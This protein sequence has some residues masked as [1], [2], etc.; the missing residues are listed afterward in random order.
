MSSAEVRRLVIGVGN[1]DRGDDGA[2]PAVVAHLRKRN[3][4][5]IALKTVSGEA[6]ELIRAWQDADSVVIVDAARCG[7]AAGTVR[8][9]DIGAPDLAIA[10][11]RASTHGLGVAEA[12]ALAR[13]IGVLPDDGVV[14]TIAGENFRPGESLSGPVAAAVAA[15]AA[16][17]ADAAQPAGR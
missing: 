11:N 15:V 5:G 12:I 1:P 6:T 9:F 8:E 7:L 16:R 14:I 4:P 10:S 13:N 17:I 3:L 2:G